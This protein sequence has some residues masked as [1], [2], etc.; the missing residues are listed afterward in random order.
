MLG[1]KD[2]LTEMA[3][4][5]AGWFVVGS[6]SV[7]G[8]ALVGTE[9]QGF[10]AAAPAERIVVPAGRSCIGRSCFA[11]GVTPLARARVQPR[12][13]A[14]NYVE[15]ESNVSEVEEEISDVEDAEEV[16]PLMPS[17]FEVGIFNTPLLRKFLRMR[18]NEFSQLTRSCCPGPESAH[19]GLR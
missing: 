1:S 16:N 14:T 18:L 4:A 10:A 8:A 15:E 2:C 5:A 3:L 12:A 13:L 11:T 7:E 6:C 17:A 19:A 9:R